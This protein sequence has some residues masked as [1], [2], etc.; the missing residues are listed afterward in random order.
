VAPGHTEKIKIDAA[1][2]L[3]LE[4]SKMNFSFLQLRFISASNNQ[5]ADSLVHIKKNGDDRYVWIFRAPEG[6]GGNRITDVMVISR[7]EV[8]ANLKT[9]VILHEFDSDPFESMQ[10]LAPGFPSVLIRMNKVA[11]A[12]TAITNFMN[13]VFE[14]WP[15]TTSYADAV[16][17]VDNDNAGDLLCSRPLAVEDEDDEDEDEDEEGETEAEAEEEETEEEGSWERREWEWWGGGRREWQR[18]ENAE[19]LQKILQ[20]QRQ[21]NL[22]VEH[23]S[24]IH[25][26]K[27]KAE[28]Q[29]KVESL[30][31]TV[32]MAA[33]PGTG[34][35]QVKETEEEKREKAELLQK[36][37]Q[38]RRQ[39][40]LIPEHGSG[41]QQA[42]EMV[43]DPRCE[44]G[45]PHCEC[46]PN[47][48]PQNERGNHLGRYFIN[49]VAYVP[50][51]VDDEMPPLVPFNHNE[52][53]HTTPQ[54]ANREDYVP[55]CPGAPP[56]VHRT[57]TMTRNGP[58]VHTYFS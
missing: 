56:R 47:E 19:L 31:M 36:M 27:E 34:N 21:A 40:N 57:T 13:I 20:L 52:P 4:Y 11:L 14:N 25:Q 23:G 54:R 2:A 37:L 28:L 1:G 10:I 9:F 42:K 41:I 26:A 12:F 24:G 45:S 48:P 51:N 22:I 35:L 58:R 43:V 46:N 38:L 33:E 3:P 17:Y 15:Q 6:S 44:E 39:V 5:A 7:A 30:G 18:R 29:K 55:H 50:E 16:K 32:N 49:G 8:L 53:S